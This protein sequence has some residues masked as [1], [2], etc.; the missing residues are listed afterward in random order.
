MQLID[1]P[2]ED[3]AEFLESYGFHRPGLDRLI[4][5]TYFLLDLVTF[6]TAA[7]TEARA[8]TIK[9][10][11]TASKAAGII[12]SDFERGFIRAETVHYTVFLEEG[13]ETAVREKG[14]M[15]SEGRDYIVQ[16]GDLILFRFNV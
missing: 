2:E 12:H 14:L 15:R 11:T 9:C 1:L 7:S 16:D 5:K 4:H 8:W 3:R 13:S 6:F 10:G